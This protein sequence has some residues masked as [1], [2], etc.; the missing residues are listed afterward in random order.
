[1]EELRDCS[2]HSDACIPRRHGT[3]VD[4]DSESHGIAAIAL[5]IE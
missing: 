4:V 5:L 1:V 2:C 3:R